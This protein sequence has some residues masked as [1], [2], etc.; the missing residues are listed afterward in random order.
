MTV[1]HCI[2]HELGEKR[3]DSVPHSTYDTHVHTPWAE[4]VRIS[5]I[6]LSIRLHRIIPYERRTAFRGHSPTTICHLLL[7]RHSLVVIF[8]LSKK[9][10]FVR[11]SKF[12]LSFGVWCL[13]FFNVRFLWTANQ[14]VHM[15][16]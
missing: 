9:S 11:R 2:A 12:R 5:K 4:V 8:A 6:Y 7:Y 1:T 10:A 16:I 14:P 13:L 3:V 15:K